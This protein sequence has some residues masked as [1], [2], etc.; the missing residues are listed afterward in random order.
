MADL[1]VV[2]DA[3][4]DARAAAQLYGAL[5]PYRGRLV[6]WAGA[7]TSWGPV[8][9]YLGQLAARLGRTGDAVRHFQDAIE[10]ERQTGA[11][12]CLAHSLAGLAAALTARDDTGDAAQASQYRRRARQVAERLG[13]AVLLQRL[14]LPADEW[15]LT[16][17][18]EDWL[19]EAGE[20]VP[21][22]AMA[23]ACTTCAPCSPR[24]GRRFGP[25]T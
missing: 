7:A 16:P 22:C 9:H 8:S 10:F 2:A 24:R 20:E 4:G 1:A 15:T 6:V 12:P 25:W 21:G 18:G 23:A 14:G 5:A 13:M 3:V 19:L 17:D 11:L